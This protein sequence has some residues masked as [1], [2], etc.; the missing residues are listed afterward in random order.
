MEISLKKNCTIDAALQRENELEKKRWR[1]ILHRLLDIVLF[2]ARM[3]LPF[4]G[5]RESVDSDNKGN[6]LEL[7][8]FLSNYDLT[9]K[10]HFT[11]IR[12]A[13]PSQGRVTSYLSPS[14]QNEFIHLLGEHL[15][16]EIIKDIR[17]AKY[18]GIMFDSTPEVSHTDQMCEVIR[19]VHIENGEVA[20]TQSF[21]GFFEI[22]GKTAAELT[23]Q[24]FKQLQ[25]DGIDIN[26]CRSQCYDNA[27]TMAGIHG[28]VQARIRE[29]NKKALFV[30]CANH[31]L[32]LCGVHSFESVKACLTFFGT[33]EA[34]Y[35]FFSASPQRWQF[36]K[37]AG[38]AV[39]KLSQTRWSA[40]Y[41][42]VH[43]VEQKL[44]DVIATLEDLCDTKYN[45]ETR[46][47]AL[48][49]VPAVCNFSF[50]SFLYF[51]RQVLEEVNHTQNYLQ[52]EGISLENCTR[53]LRALKIFLED[54]RA[55][56]VEKAVARATE[57]CD[58]LN[59][60]VVKRVRFRK[61]M[62]GE[63]GKDAGLTAQEE[64]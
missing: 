9:L 5:H 42:A 19:Y 21:L 20:V 39:K 27:A 22:E 36:L 55:E 41:D 37:N 61:L 24:I 48:N 62:P 26:L 29:V 17:K 43:A 46:R 63:T 50:L 1:D 38:V 58:L 14:T 12:T 8:E 30:P 54:D 53:K 7:V 10:E 44:D 28:G 35:S 57:K 31:S 56:V 33:L 49:L 47:G 59:I 40:H 45:A 15:K 3:N 60:E 34:V 2:L 25:E 23:Q 52:T 13:I 11:R 51:W 64:V 4:R 6:F 18:F 32:N 16:K